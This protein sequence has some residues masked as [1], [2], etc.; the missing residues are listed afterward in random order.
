MSQNRRLIE[1]SIPLDAIS[2]QS[3]REKSIRHGHISTLHI[4][5]AR[6][7]LAACRAAVFASLV[8]APD[9]E[10]EQERLE[11]LIATI[12]DWDQVKHGNSPKIEEARNIIREQWGDEIPR[13]LDMFAG[14]GAI[15]LEALRLGCEAHALELNPV[16]YLILLSTLVYPQKYGRAGESEN[17]QAARPATN[18]LQSTLPGMESETAEQ[19]RLVADVRR[20][21]EW[22]LEEARKEVGR[23]YK[24]PDGNT[25]VAYLWARTA[26]CPNPA[27]GAEMPLV[28]QWWLAKKSNKKIALKPVVNREKKTVR[29]EVVELPSPARGRGAGGEGFD[30]SQ[31]T[32]RRG[33]VTCLFCGQTADAKYLRN[34]GKAGRLG[35]MPLAVVLAPSSSQG[36]GRGGGQHGKTYRPA[37][38]ADQ[39]VYAEAQAALERLLAEADDGLSPVPD[40]PV[41]P[42]P[43]SV[44]RLPMY[45]MPTWGDVFNARQALALVTFSRKVRAAYNHVLAE[46][47]DAEYARAVTTYLALAL[48]RQA[49]QCT[50]LC[51]WHNTG[52]KLE[53]L[54]A[55]QAIPMVWDYAEVNPFSGSTGDWLSALSWINNVIRHCSDDD[56]FPAVVH[57]GTATRLPR[58]NGYFHAIVTDPPYY[59]AVPYADL[60]DF[61]YVWLKRTV[62]DLYPEVFRTPLTPK[63]A[64]IIQEPGRH[65]KDQEKAKA[66]YEAQMTAAFSEAA[67]VL[68]PDGIMVLVFAHKSTSAWETLIT[69]LLKASLVV[70]A[71]WPLHTEM[72]TRVRAMETASLASSIFLVCRK[73]GEAREGYYNEVR[74]ELQERIRERLDFF[75]E[76]GIR[77][78]DFFISAIGPAV[79]VFGRYT[80]VRRLSGETVSVGELLDLVQEFVADYALTRI[81]RDGHVGRVDPATRFYVLWRWAYGASKVPF[82]DARKLAQAQ[83]TEV[84]DLMLRTKLLKKRGE[85]VELLGP[86]QR[87]RDEHLGESGPGGQMVPLIDV[88][89]RACVLWDQGNRAGLT[90]FL[91]R[92]GH[93]RDE[94]LWV[95]AQALAEILP[96]GDKEKQMLQGLLMNKEQVVNEMRQ[97]RLFEV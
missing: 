21:G 23:F 55:R 8:D 56:N 80:T 3:A 40:E 89:H 4:W 93:A 15:P 81:L 70:T 20:W 34:E 29:F 43:H 84:D 57:Q 32:M 18:T 67:R 10:A 97:G 30:P 85:N 7:P 25:I 87:A 82:D 95:V 61:F 12:S 69:S 64:E 72:V 60:S 11:K 31:G 68:R 48:D 36:E 2:K 73:R 27:C 5:W 94:A 1:L 75:W 66:F 51:R 50:N 86:R 54:F 24:D 92:S 88:L 78:A 28:R 96:E 52:E 63:A 90:E 44:N 16:A 17:Q 77:G 19:N 71:S 91:A 74:R 22:V 47:G 39:Q 79:E 49:N 59:D 33:S 53:G 26:R 58:P 6:R 14:G 37:T 62:G 46:T 38:E 65:S 41:D 45:G 35:Q 42:R 13:V 83:G 76:K 9:D